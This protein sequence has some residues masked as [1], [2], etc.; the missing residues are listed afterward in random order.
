MARKAR[1]DME[2]ASRLVW[3]SQFPSTRSPKHPRS[4]PSDCYLVKVAATERHLLGRV[5]GDTA[6]R[7]LGWRMSLREGA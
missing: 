2:G 4:L 7:A 1:D 5:H 6:G 3:A